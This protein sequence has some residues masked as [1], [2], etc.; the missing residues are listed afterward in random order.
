ME[1]SI[2][3]VLVPAIASIG[4]ILGIINTYRDWRRDKIKL[5]VTSGMT[6]A[7]H[8]NS[9][10]MSLT[11]S[12]TNLSSIAVS[13]QRVTIA[14]KYNK[15]LTFPEVMAQLPIRLEPRTSESVLFPHFIEESPDC[16]PHLTDGATH[17]IVETA[18]GHT[19]KIKC[20]FGIYTGAYQ[21]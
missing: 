11:V 20:D 17:I 12:V 7:P 9:N 16:L 5:R 18:C 21:K 8:I 14:L 1:S 3:D 13:W 19:A 15:R 4:M 2:K 6:I 10:I